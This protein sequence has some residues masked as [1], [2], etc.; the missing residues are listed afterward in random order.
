MPARNI[1][2]N[3]SPVSRCIETNADL[4]WS[5]Q[6]SAVIHESGFTGIM[7]KTNLTLPKLQLGIAYFTKKPI[8]IKL[9]D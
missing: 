5:K 6:S 8:S 9:L 2:L 7:K 4:W 1:P 3:G